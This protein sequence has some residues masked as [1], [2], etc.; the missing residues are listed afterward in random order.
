MKLPAEIWKMIEKYIV[1]FSLAD[2][3]VFPMVIC[4]RMNHS[5]FADY[6]IAFCGDHRWEIETANIVQSSLVAQYFKKQRLRIEWSGDYILTRER[7]FG[8]GFNISNLFIETFETEEFEREFEERIDPILLALN[9]E[10]ITDDDEEE[11]Q[12]LF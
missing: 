7:V 12:D 3:L 8:R 6:Y 2:K 4:E 10:M 5:F 11:E 9:L 1:I